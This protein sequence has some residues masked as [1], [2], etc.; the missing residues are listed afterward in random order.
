VDILTKEDNEL[1][2]CWSAWGWRA[3]MH[4][5]WSWRSRHTFWKWP[6]WPLQNSWKGARPQGP[7]GQRGLNGRKFASDTCVHAGPVNVR[8]PGCWPN[9]TPAL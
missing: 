1:R 2:A 5:K 3:T 6:P 9:R 7:D 8:A 4:S